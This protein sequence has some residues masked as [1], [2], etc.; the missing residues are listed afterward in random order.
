[1]LLFERYSRD[2][3]WPLTHSMQPLSL[4]YQFKIL[5][6]R[7]RFQESK[8]LPYL[9]SFLKVQYGLKGNRQSL[10]LRFLTASRIALVEYDHLN[11]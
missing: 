9:R 10:C 7:T 6:A 11:V 2:W 3:R 8:V 5:C 4:P 1:M